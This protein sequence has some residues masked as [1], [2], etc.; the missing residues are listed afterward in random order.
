MI[1]SIK[2]N[3][4]I[5]IIGDYKFLGW[6]TTD[7]P[8]KYI[9]QKAIVFSN[10]QDEESELVLYEQ[11]KSIKLIDFP[12]DRIEFLIDQIS[13]NKLSEPLD[14]LPYPFTGIGIGV[15]DNPVSKSFFVRFDT[16][17]E[18]NKVDEN[19]DKKW[20][21]DFYFS[22]INEWI[23]NSTDIKAKYTQD[24]FLSLEIEI[25]TIGYSTIE[26]AV[27]KAIRELNEI[28][29]KVEYSLNGLSGIFSVIEIWNE[30][31]YIQ[32]EDFWRQLFKRNS[33]I[34]SI[35][36]NEPTIILE[37][38]AFLGGKSISNGEGKLLDFILKNRLSQNV[39]LIEIKK[40]QSKLLAAKYRGVFSLSTDLTGA[41]N[42]LLDYRD[43]LSK[44]FFSINHYTAHSFEA[45]FPKSYLVIGSMDTLN[46]A[47]R[48]CFE[49]YRR[50][51]M[52][53]EIITFDELF[54][55]LFFVLALINT[56]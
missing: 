4:P 33:W 18:K 29:K 39:A 31:K 38:E 56:K 15:A 36:L 26:D 16:I 5:L 7:M 11:I 53:V 49:L 2:D 54:D 44:N 42:Q 12:D 48:K 20:T 32:N 19:W 30:N 6:R 9:N 51:L 40:P 41:I 24:N 21:M 23:S 3:V 34:L 22:N 43:T 14:K 17:Q 35:A 52:G 1:F 55:K 46:S 27:N 10:D 50:H 13:I 45:I 37:N 47:Q 28:L 25:L 8:P